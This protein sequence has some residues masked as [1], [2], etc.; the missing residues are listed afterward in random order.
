MPSYKTKALVLKKTKLGETDLIIT[1]LDEEGAQRRAVAKG[2]R[3]PG[4]FLAAR[5][6]LYMLVEAQL[7]TGR[8]LDI[9]TDARI[10]EAH[11]ACRSDLEHSAAAAVVVELVEKTTAQHN[12][13]PLLYAMSL[14]AL[15]QIGRAEGAAPVMISLACALKICA[16][17]GV[18]PDTS[19]L[20]GADDRLATWIT[21]LLG[22][23]FA[24]LA[25]LEGS[26]YLPVLR[27]LAGFCKQWIAQHLD[28]KLKSLDFVEGLLLR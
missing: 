22:A 1:L 8:T 13:E 12:A 17:L 25:T 4:S 5:L 2:A 19:E 7:A 15:E 20:L 27:G 18:Q 9:V 21:T 6:E 23:R 3:K 14:A 24:E 16:A 28:I 26:E 11:T 10:L